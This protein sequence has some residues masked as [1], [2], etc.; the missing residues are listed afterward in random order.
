MAKKRKVTA[1]NRAFGTAAKRANSK[2]HATTK[3]TAAF[4][5]CKNTVMEVELR[6]AKSSLG[7]G[8][9]RKAASGAT[10][11]CAGLRSTGPKKGTLKKGYTWKG[12]RG[13]CPVKAKG[14]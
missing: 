3:T 7:V 2:C 5:R 11:K 13:G 6:K 8:K 4:Q 1:W 12:K 10:K 9:K 14:R